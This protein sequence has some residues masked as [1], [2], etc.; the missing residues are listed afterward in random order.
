ME[1]IK[2][3]DSYSVFKRGDMRRYNFIQCDDTDENRG[4]MLRK[5]G[6]N[7]R[8]IRKRKNLTQE[9]LAEIARINPKYLGEIERGLKNPTARIV[10]KVADA[11]DVRLCEIV[12][13]KACTNKT[14]RFRTEIAEMLEG[15]EE[16]QWRKA[17]KVL[18]VF[19]E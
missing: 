11:L 10:Q 5:V 9:A 14:D 4:L 13:A 1:V 15:K 18:R 6:S 16:E 19:F 17:L 12:V 7:I 3:F 2:D 8:Q